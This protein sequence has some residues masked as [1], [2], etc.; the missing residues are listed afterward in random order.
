M[1]GFQ[2]FNEVCFHTYGNYSCY[3]IQLDCKASYQG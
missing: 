3:N 2:V 1:N